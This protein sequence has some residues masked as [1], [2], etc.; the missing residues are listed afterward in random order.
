MQ[1]KLVLVGGGHAHMVVLANLDRF[2]A[3]GH[4]VT[5]IGP[6]P[7][8]YYSGMGPGMLSKTYS[9]REIR[10]DTRR[11]VETKKG[12]FVLGKA[13]RIDPQLKNI[14]LASG[15]MIAYDVLSCNVGSYVPEPEITGNREAVFTVKPIERLLAAQQ[16][17]LMLAGQKGRHV[18]IIGGG[19]SGVEIAGN[20]WRLFKDNGGHMPGI[21]LFAGRGLMRRFPLSI[22]DRVRA[23]LIRRGIGIQEEGYVKEI[24]AGKVVSDT[25]QSRFFDLILLA[26]GIKPSPLFVQSGLPT[27]PDGGLR[28]NPYLQCPDFPEIFG[29]GDCIHFQ[30]QPLNKV[31]VYAVRQNPILHHNLMAALEGKSLLPFD[32]GGEYL[33][34]FNLG[35]GTGILRKGRILFGG[36]PAFWVKD[37]IDRRFMQKFQKMA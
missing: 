2:I 15:K 25:G 6:S 36:R 12:R 37:Y 3:R 16:Q 23:S 11:G 28:V 29:G 21:T 5:V 1:K 35:D 33:L 22:A 19:P 26:P 14:H 27:G 13:V 4:Q 7:Y 18:A 30:E 31:G 34:I 9:A 32:P 10:F 8:H 17:L 24:A 20:T